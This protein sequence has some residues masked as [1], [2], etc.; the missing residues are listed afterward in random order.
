M[1]GEGLVKNNNKY[2]RNKGRV[3][4]RELEYRVRKENNKKYFNYTN[5]TR[6]GFNL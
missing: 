2:M 5:I 1:T 6:V 4:F 3:D